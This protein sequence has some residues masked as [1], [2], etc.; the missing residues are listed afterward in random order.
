[1]AATINLISN[2]YIVLLKSHF[3]LATYLL[4]SNPLIVA[5]NYEMIMIC[6][7]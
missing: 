3:Q 1:V 7:S 6:A 2:D 5:L 4:S